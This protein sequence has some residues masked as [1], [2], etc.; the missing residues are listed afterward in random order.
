MSLSRDLGVS[1][2]GKTD[3]KVIDRMVE[4]SAGFARHEL[5]YASRR[6][7]YSEDENIA[8]AATVWAAT[9]GH[10][11]HMASVVRSKG[12]PKQRAFFA[13]RYSSYEETMKSTIST[14]E[15][16]YHWAVR[17]PKDRKEM[18]DLI[19]GNEWA[20][21]WAKEIGDEEEMKKKINIR[22]WKYKFEQEIEEGKDPSFT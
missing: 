4:S 3:R 14:S 13:Y 20:F 5:R 6:F 16:A 17:F 21:R 15:G 10:R 18:K 9:V 8:K 2:L 11:D 7:P 12:T 22:F 1:T 19:G